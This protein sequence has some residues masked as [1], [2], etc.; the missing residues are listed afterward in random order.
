MNKRLETL[1]SY[2]PAGKGLIDVGSDHGFLPVELAKNGYS[3]LLFASDIHPD[4]LDA[5]RRTAAKAGL[6]GR[7]RFLLCDGLSLCDPDQIDTIVIAGMGGDLIC[8]ILDQA[9]WTMDPGYTILLQP[10]TKAEVLRYWLS[11]NDYGI[12]AEDLVQDGGKLYQLML[13][14]F[15]QAEPLTDAELYTGSLRL[16]RE[17]PLFPQLLDTQIDRIRTQLNGL[18]QSRASGHPGRQRLLRGI[19]QELEEM[20]K[21]ENS[22]RDLSVS[23]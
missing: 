7:I 20:R 22:R 21:N 6:D 4:P 5:A 12:L 2:I 10:M 19:L 14:R 1:M 9:E 8:R 23:L 17:N 18:E 3:G 15:G 13:V 11:N 16:V